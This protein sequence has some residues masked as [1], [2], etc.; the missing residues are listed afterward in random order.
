MV[1]M[2][3]QLSDDIV[4]L[5]LYC[6]FSF[7]YTFSPFFFRIHFC[8]ILYSVT[9]R[10]QLATNSLNSSNHECNILTSYMHGL[11]E[12]KHQENLI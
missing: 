9:T 3:E 4:F 12:H 11:L 10:E 6:P 1:R 7:L 2:M 8:L 5:F